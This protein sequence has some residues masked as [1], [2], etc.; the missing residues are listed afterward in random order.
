MKLK[1]L[2]LISFKIITRWTSI[3][4]TW[5]EPVHKANHEPGQRE[6]E[7]A[8]VSKLRV[9]LDSHPVVYVLPCSFSNRDPTV[10]KVASVNEN[11]PLVELQRTAHT[12]KKG[13]TTTVFVGTGKHQAPRE[14]T[15]VVMRFNAKMLSVERCSG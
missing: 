12:A 2:L 3:H 6:N 11:L 14:V 5:M 13:S 4:Y 10:E 8:S 7:S 1:N 9:P 15:T